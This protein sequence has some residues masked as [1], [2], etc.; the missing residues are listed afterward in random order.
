MNVVEQLAKD[1]K[2]LAQEYKA[3]AKEAQAILDKIE[4]GEHKKTPTRQR[5]NTKHSQK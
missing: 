1:T 4:I 5:K 3:L 2:K